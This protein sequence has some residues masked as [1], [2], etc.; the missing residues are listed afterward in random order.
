VPEILMEHFGALGVPLLG[1][2]PIGHG[3]QQTAIALGVPAVLDADTGTLTVQ[4]VGQ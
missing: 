3:D 1:G 4:P 2:L